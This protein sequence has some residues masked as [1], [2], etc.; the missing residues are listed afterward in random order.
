MDETFVTV[1]VYNSG[2]EAEIA[3][4]RLEDEE[5]EAFIFDDNTIGMVPV[6][7]TMLGGVKLKTAASNAERATEIL[8]EVQGHPLT[9]DE[10]ADIRCPQC[11][12]GNIDNGF[13]H[14]RTFGAKAS[15]IA[16]Y[17]VL[18]VPI[19][20][21]SVYKCKDCGFEFPTAAEF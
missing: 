14:A 21:D 6:L 20:S 18:G 17:M 10:G 12:S 3:R 13:V 19:S 2:I 7:S 16:S 4:T 9:D 5:I 1:A 15:A 8:R 11:G